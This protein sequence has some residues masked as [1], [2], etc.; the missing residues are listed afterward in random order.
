MKKSLFIFL[1]IIIL[2]Q[3]AQASIPNNEQYAE[4][5]QKE[6]QAIR[7]INQVGI[8]T[9]EKF[10]NDEEKFSTQYAFNGFMANFHNIKEELASFEQKEQIP[11]EQTLNVCT[12][13]LDK[14]IKEMQ[15]YLK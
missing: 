10:S 14:L 3:L 8:K 6:Q 13:R 9:N 11:D 1:I 4:V 2:P 5:V 7:L 15:I 12:K